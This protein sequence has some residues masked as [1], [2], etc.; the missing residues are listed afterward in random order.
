[1][2]P[3]S[4][5]V[6]GCRKL[7]L[8]RGARELLLP[9]EY[10]VSGGLARAVSEPLLAE[11]VGEDD[12]DDVAGGEGD[13][14][15]KT[16]LKQPEPGKEHDILSLA[17]E[18]VK[19]ADEEEREERREKELC[20]RVREVQEEMVLLRNDI[21]RLRRE[22]ETGVEEVVEG[23]DEA[24]KLGGNWRKLGSGDEPEGSSEN[25]C[26]KPKCD[27]EE[28]PKKVL[29][30]EQSDSVQTLPLLSLPKFQDCS[31][32][33]SLDLSPPTEDTA[34]NHLP[35]ERPKTHLAKLP[36]PERRP[37]R[38]L[39][40]IRQGSSE[41]RGRGSGGGLGRGAREL[42]GRTGD[43]PGKRD[44]SDFSSDDEVQNYISM[45]LFDI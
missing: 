36:T 41:L 43:G 21:W 23:G 2:T 10:M 38:E 8:L 6:G 40:F 29:S 25:D 22:E 39:S 20:E 11:G 37:G 44:E 24:N 33:C 32:Q 18:F 28:K 5:S 13:Q 15:N 26:N 12:D 16:E 1:M 35:L 14:C 19:D 42:E 3:L 45:G 34:T 31:V 9:A 4:L 7:L 30:N 17:K 27:T